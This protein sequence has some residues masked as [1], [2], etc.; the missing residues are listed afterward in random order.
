MTT[1]KIAITEDDVRN[2]IRSKRLIVKTGKLKPKESKLLNVR[3]TSI[4]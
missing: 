3:C 2:V 4:N 1:R